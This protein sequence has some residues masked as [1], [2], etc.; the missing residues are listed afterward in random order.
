M[1]IVPRQNRQIYLTYLYVNRIERLAVDTPIERWYSY[2]TKY[3][4]AHRYGKDN[5]IYMN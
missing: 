2:L 4:I 3:M 1:I 5:I